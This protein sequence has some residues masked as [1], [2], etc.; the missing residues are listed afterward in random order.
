MRTN[1]NACITELIIYNDIDEEN[2]I[3]DQDLLELLV[4][5]CS[6][7]P[8]IGLKDDTVRRN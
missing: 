4:I 2:L 7:D 8:Y 3:D 1:Q 6:Y 5:I